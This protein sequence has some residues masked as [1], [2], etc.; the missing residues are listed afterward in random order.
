M[1]CNKEGRVTKLE[2][3]LDRLRMEYGEE[4][5]MRTM[6]EQQY[7]SLK[8]KVE[9]QISRSFFYI[10]VLRSDVPSASLGSMAWQ[11]HPTK[12]GRQEEGGSAA[13]P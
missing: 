5:A 3:Q 9:S 10:G 13:P 7:V 11:P 8:K 12:R 4:G 6:V 1:F 2:G